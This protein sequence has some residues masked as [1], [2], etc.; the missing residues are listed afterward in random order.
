MPPPVWERTSPTLANLWRVH[1]H[2]D[3]TRLGRTEVPDHLV[4]PGELT[5]IDARILLALGNRFPMIR[6]HKVLAAYSCLAPRLVAGAFDPTTHRAIWPST[7]NYARGGVAISQ[8]MGCRGVAVLPEGMS[9]ERFEWLAEWITDPSDVIRTYG[10]ESNVKEIYDACKVLAEDPGNVI[11]NQFSEFSNHLGHYRVTGPALEHVFNAAGGVR[12]AAY[13]S[14]SGL[15]GNARRRGLSEGAARLSHRPGGGVRVPDHALQRLRR[16]QHPGHRRQAHPAHPQRRQLR[17]RGR[18]LRSRHRL[19]VRAVQ[20]PRRQGPSGRVGR[21]P[22]ARREPASHGLSSIANML[23]AIKL[24]KHHRLSADDVIVTVATDGAEMYTSEFEPIIERDH[25]VATSTIGRRPPSTPA[26]SKVSTPTTLLELTEV[27]RRKR[28]FNLGY[29]TWV[30]Q[31]GVD[32]EVFERRR[33]QSWWDAARLHRPLGRDDR[34]V[35]RTGHAGDG[36]GFRQ[37]VSS[38]TATRLDS[39]ADG[40]GERPVGRRVRRPRRANRRGHRRGRRAWHR[41]V[42][43]MLMSPELADRSRSRS[44]GLHIKDDTGN[45]GGSHKARHLFGVMLHLAVA[46]HDRE[47][48]LAVASCG[49]AALAAA[50][51]ARAIHRPLRVFIPT[52]ADPAVVDFP[53]VAGRDDRGRRTSAGR[54]MAILTYLRFRR[55]GQAAGADSLLRAGDGDSDH[56]GRRAARSDG[57]WPTN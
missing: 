49:N 47:G 32:F 46:R 43:P 8:I 41:H 25:P 6:A 27:D 9:R 45:V 54:V 15:G 19:A 35:Q 30:E 20:H 2:N 29:Y 56:I 5:G 22:D 40:H 34:R 13:V 37:P 18:H 44:V 38:A 7:G 55:G 33:D 1:W 28:I 36:P 14:A 3:H 50:T 17:R 48:E 57:S 53:R 51:L 23:A 10:T 12:L 24:A 26:I 4:L 39:Y 21:R 11:L 52:W 31:Q 42:T 16:A